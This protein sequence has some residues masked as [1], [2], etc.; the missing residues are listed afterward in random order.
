MGNNPLPLLILDCIVI[1]GSVYLV[2][3]PFVSRRIRDRWAKRLL[4]AVGLIGVV[5]YTMK[6]A[7]HSHWLVVSPLIGYRL[8][9]FL[10]F[11]N[12]VLLGW[13]TAVFFSGQVIGKKVP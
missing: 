5:C 2:F 6:F 9:D 1:A 13:A 3:V 4:F 7:L 11:I 12:G 8:G 10:S